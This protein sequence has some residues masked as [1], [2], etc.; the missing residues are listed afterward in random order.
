ML[1]LVVI[2]S[3]FELFGFDILLDEECNP[4][5]MEVCIYISLFFSLIVQLTIMD[6]L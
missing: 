2:D 5:L 3:C 4:W 6:L 1:I